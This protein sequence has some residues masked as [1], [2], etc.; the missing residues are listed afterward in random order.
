MKRT[1]YLEQL[2]KYL[3]RLPHEDYV[4]AMDYFTEYFDEAGPENEVQVIEN[5]G[6]PKEAANEIIHNILGKHL[7]D[8]E[9]TPCKR[10]Q[11]AWIAILA[12]LASPIAFPLALFIFAASVT[13]IA[14]GFAAIAT[15][16]AISLAAFP[17][18]VMIIYGGFT[19]LS[20]SIS[21]TILA[22]G[23]GLL[24]IGLALLALFVIFELARLLFK[25]VGAAI[26]WGINKGRKS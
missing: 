15:V 25:G 10:A 11:I 23:L 18:G 24:A 1:E 8:D 13:V 6:S 9:K 20:T 5:L 2:D 4:E 21:A 14:I 3:K 16:I 19:Y 17:A 12:V 22:I 26:R 7:S